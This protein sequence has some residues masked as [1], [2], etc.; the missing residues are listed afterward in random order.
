MTNQT[1]AIFGVFRKRAD[2]A[3]AIALLKKVGFGSEDI[4]VMFPENKGAQDFPQVQKNQ[5]RNGAL[6]GAIVGVIVIGTIGGF[7]AAGAFPS[8][9]FNSNV[10]SGAQA[11]MLGPILTVFVS[12]VL[13]GLAGAAFGTLVGM[14]TPDTAGKR[15]GQYVHAGGILLSVQSKSAEQLE[16]AKMI[17]DQAGADDINQ[18]DESEGWR[19]AVDEEHQ[20]IRLDVQDYERDNLTQA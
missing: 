15:Y 17:L 10:I 7:V 5:L 2:I 16:R 18:I 13:G 6:I 19:D 8:L 3:E 4:S 11:P 12:I 9:S 1:T 20:L 14:G